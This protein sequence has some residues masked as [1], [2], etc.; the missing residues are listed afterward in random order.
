M[1]WWHPDIS[2]EDLLKLVKG[3]V[4]ILILASGYQSSGSFAHWDTYNI[5]KAFQWGIFFENVF[6]RLRYSDDYEGSIKELDAAL[7]EIKSNP[8][9][10]QGIAH[11]SSVTLRQASN[12]VLQ[13]LLHALPLRDAHLKAFAIAAIEMDLSELQRTENDCIEVYLRRLV[14]QKS[15]ADPD[16]DCRAFMEGSL[17]SSRDV[18]NMK[19]D[20]DFTRPTIQELAKRQLAVSCISSAEAGLD[21]LCKSIRQRNWNESDSSSFK[22]LQNHATAPQTED[23]LIDYD[24]WNCWR[25]HALSYFINRRTI[26]LVSGASMIF[27]ASEAQWVQ[28]FEKLNISAVNSDDMVEILLLGCVASKWSSLIEHFMLVSYD[29]ISISRQYH[30][31]CSFPLRRIQN[32][33]SREE[34]MSPKVKS[35]LKHL[36]VLLETQPHQLWKLSPALAA[37]GIPSWSP[38]FRLYLSELDSQF[39]GDSTTIRRCCCVQDRKEHKDCELAERI[40]CLYIYHVSGSHLKPRMNLAQNAGRES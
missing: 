22:E 6:R 33:H 19:I 24:T 37:V 32:L 26:G 29:S 3:F 17:I 14:L 34:M 27:S 30:E 8:F 40:W 16:L 38:L 7:S 36:A 18:S 1:G 4:D 5:K 25:T 15:C 23:Q 12:F 9:F 13:Y 39:K 10:P 28:V 31:V 20:G 11:L 2:L 21:I 35:I